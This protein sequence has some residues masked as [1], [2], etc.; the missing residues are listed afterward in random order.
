[1][2]EGRR[3]D[4]GSCVW[5]TSLG[6]LGLLVAGWV[7]SAP[8]AVAIGRQMYRNSEDAALGIYGST[9]SLICGLIDDGRED[10]RWRIEVGEHRLF[11]LD[12]L[13]TDAV[14]VMIRPG[15]WGAVISATHLST[16]VGS[17]G[18]LGVE[19]VYVE[20]GSFSIAA[21]ARIDRLTLPGFEDTYLAAASVRMFARVSAGLIVGY[22]ADTI[23]VAGEDHPGT[24][25]G[26]HVIV[27]PGSPVCLLSRLELSRG[28]TPSVGIAA[29]V[30]PGR[31]LRVAAGY[32][33]AS[34]GLAGAITC[35]LGPIG[36]RA[37][38]EV[39]P[40]LGVSKSVFV[41]WGGG[42]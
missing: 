21:G 32:D 39:H 19:G 33:G 22:T 23:R 9:Y 16:P 20:N 12:D 40:V 38:A 8:D 30:R 14:S 41:F 10:P 4:A 42:S 13:K 29:S 26:C 5:R 2:P 7:T 18:V 28:G 6:L 15:N 34:G 11:S 36:L 35:T 25:L 37:G 31:W 24:G 3:G 27:C 1:M 17:E